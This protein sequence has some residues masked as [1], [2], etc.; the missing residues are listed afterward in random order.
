MRAPRS[1]GRATGS[2]RGKDPSEGLEVDVAYR[3]VGEQERD[4]DPRPCEQ[5]ASPRM[6]HRLRLLGVDGND[7]CP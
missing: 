3:D 6:L 4:R 7:H 5:P 2:S 1:P